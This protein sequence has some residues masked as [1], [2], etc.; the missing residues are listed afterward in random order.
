MGVNNENVKNNLLLKAQQAWY[1]KVMI[2]YIIDHTDNGKYN[3]D[4]DGK[5]AAK[6]IGRAAFLAPEIVTSP[7]SFVGP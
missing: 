7:W 4:E 1:E 6:R 5:C 3:G 2:P